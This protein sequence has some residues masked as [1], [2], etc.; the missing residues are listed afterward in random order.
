MFKKIEKWNGSLIYYTADILIQNLS[1]YKECEVNVNGTKLLP[2]LKKLSHLNAETSSDS[3]YFV[4]NCSPRLAMFVYKNNI[5]KRFHLMFWGSV[6]FYFIRVLDNHL[7]SQFVGVCVDKVHIYNAQRL[8]VSFVTHLLCIQYCLTSLSVNDVMMTT[9][10][11]SIKS[12]QSC[13]Y[14][15]C[16]F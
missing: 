6:V 14:F 16:L 15:L 13:V 5:H 3:S 10:L 12:Y 2:R 9:F 11:K 4:T 8:Q 1:K 7:A